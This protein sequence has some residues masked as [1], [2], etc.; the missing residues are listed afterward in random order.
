MKSIKSLFVSFLVISLLQ[1]C[2]SNPEKSEATGKKIEKDAAAED[3]TTKP[4][5]N[6]PT[7]VLP[8]GPVTPNPYLQNPPKLSDQVQA[9]F[10]AAVAAMQQKKWD[11]AEVALKQ[12]A[13][14]NPKLS[15][16]YL[17]LGIVYRNKGLN[18]KAAEEFNRAITINPKNLDAYN[19]LAV[20]KRDSGDLSAAETLYQ[21]ALAVWPFYPEGHKNIAILY[22]LYLSKPEQA[23]PH[24]QAYQQL[25]SAPDKQV[26]SWVAELQRRLNSGK[27]PATTEAK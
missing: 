8:A 21:K 3:L 16:L 1:A 6:I 11:E 9:S 13:E 14:K 7:S 18:D 5:A 20:L 23:L 26:D 10:Q 4:K 27:A 19:Q 25:L 12:L 2:G 22:D 24:Y 15:G 17:N